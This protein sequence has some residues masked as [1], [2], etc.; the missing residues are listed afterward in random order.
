M[1]VGNASAHHARAQHTDFLRFEFGY[2]HG[3]A[4]A[5]FYRVHVEEEGVD[6]VLGDLP[7]HDF[8]EVAAF[9]AQRGV[10]VDLRAFDHGA[11]GSFRRGVQAARFELEHGRRNTNQRG[12]FGVAGGTAR[13]FV[14]LGIPRLR[15]LR[16]CRNKRQGFFTQLA[17]L[18]H[19]LMNQ[20]QRQAFRRAEQLT[21]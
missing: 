1:C 3:P 4:L 6:H 13:Y 9:N 17:W 5:A 15:R 18:I 14:I 20:A 19:Q 2:A 7:R 21:L 8:C 16:M 12:N 11:Q 10:K